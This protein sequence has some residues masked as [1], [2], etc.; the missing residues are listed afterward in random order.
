MII[1]RQK[2]EGVEEGEM[3]LTPIGKKVDILPAIEI[4]EIVKG[5]Q[6]MDRPKNDGIASVEEEGMIGNDIPT[7]LTMKMK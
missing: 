3:T 5:L 1:H 2:R 4:E 6:V 7:E